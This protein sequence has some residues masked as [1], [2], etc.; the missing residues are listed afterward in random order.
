MN[1]AYY[2]FKHTLPLMMS[3]PSFLHQARFFFQQL[4]SGSKLLSLNEILSL[5]IHILDGTAQ[6]MP[7]VKIC[8]FGYSKCV[9]FL[10][11]K[12]TVGTPAYIA[13]DSFYFKKGIMMGRSQVYWS[14][15][16]TL[17]VMLV[18]SYPFEDPDD[19][20]N[21]RKTSGGILKCSLFKIPD[22]I[23]VFH[24]LQSSFYRDYLWLTTEKNLPYRADGREKAGRAMDRQT[25]C[26]K[27]LMKFLS[28]IQEASKPVLPVKGCR[29]FA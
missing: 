18:G 22:Y 6:A 23:R 2:L 13:P 12:S 8:D 17:Y 1:V 21:F 14:C 5:K 16:V 10:S 24:I 27:A 20:K 9:A 4:I 29:A 28:I 19:P 26:P 15:W 25:T 7:R 11:Q 3:L